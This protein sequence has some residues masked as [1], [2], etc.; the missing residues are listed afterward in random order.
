MCKHVAAVLYGVGARLD[1]K[2]ELLFMLRGVNHE[3]L[4]DADAEQAV[5]AA[6]SRGKSKRLAAADLGEVFGIE[7]GTESAVELNSATVRRAMARAKPAQNTTKTPASKKKSDGVCVPN[8]NASQLAPGRPTDSNRPQQA[9]GRQ[10]SA[11]GG[12]QEKGSEVR[13]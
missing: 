10:T 2:P 9:C 11:G 12:C 13:G 5:A 1:T 7:L 3:E 6:T 8:E 4:I